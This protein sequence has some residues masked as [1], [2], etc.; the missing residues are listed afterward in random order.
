MRF[1]PR[2]ESR[3]QPQGEAEIRKVW[4]QVQKIMDRKVPPAKL[5]A[6]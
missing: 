3:Q 2:P 6:R 1:L 4:E 5:P